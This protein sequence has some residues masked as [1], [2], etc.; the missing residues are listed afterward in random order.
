MILNCLSLLAHP[1]VLLATCY[2]RGSSFC[3]SLVSGRDGTCT[4]QPSCLWTLEI[5]S[6]KHTL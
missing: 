4:Y 3:R 1:P 6:P 2:V 5:P